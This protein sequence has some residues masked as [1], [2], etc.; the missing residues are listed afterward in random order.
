MIFLWSIIGAIFRRLWGGAGSFIPEFNIL[1]RYVLSPL[2]GFLCAFYF[3]GDTWL[4]LAAGLILTLAFLNPLHAYGQRMGLGGPPSFARSACVM[5]LSY[6]LCTLV[7]SSV[8]FAIGVVE[9][10]TRYGFFY[11]S[12]LGL[13]T[14]ALYIFGWYVVPRFTNVV[15]GNLTN[16]ILYL[17]KSKINGENIYYLDSTTAFG[18]NG[19]GFLLVLSI[20]LS[21]WGAQ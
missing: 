18:E 9:G 8:F 3:S 7:M 13:F 2:L 1:K 19:I 12:P 15:S 14:P 10:I 5:A 16:P 21:L 4:S 6:G 11:G 17:G 20:A